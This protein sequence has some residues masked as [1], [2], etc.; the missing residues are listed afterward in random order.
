MPLIAMPSRT[1]RAII[2]LQLV[3]H[4][5]HKVIKPKAVVVQAKKMGGPIKRIIRVAGSCAQMDATVKMKIATENLL[6][7]RP[8]SSGIEVTEAEDMMPLSSR[9]RL[10][11]SPAIVHNRRSTFLS[12]F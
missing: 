2:S 10:Q 12:T 11:S 8:K 5:V 7:V 6:P 4:A 3:A 9:L 1:R